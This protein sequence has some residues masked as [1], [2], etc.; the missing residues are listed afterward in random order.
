VAE[1]AVMAAE[2]EGR[3]AVVACN[4]Q[5]RKVIAEHQQSLALPGQLIFLIS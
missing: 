1:L 2:R 4:Q 5:K 3:A